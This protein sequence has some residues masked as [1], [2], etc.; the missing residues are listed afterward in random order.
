[1]T[2]SAISDPS[3]RPWDSGTRPAAA[4]TAEPGPRKTARCM[5]GATFADFDATTTLLMVSS[6]AP[7]SRNSTPY[8]AVSRSRTVRRGRRR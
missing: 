6:S 8:S 7:D 5:A 3:T 2:A 4:G 1:M